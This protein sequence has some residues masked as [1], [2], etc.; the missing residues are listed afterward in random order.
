MV[1]FE[2]K[3]YGTCLC[4]QHLLILL[5]GDCLCGAAC[6]VA[7]QGWWLVRQ[8]HGDSL[9]PTVGTLLGVILGVRWGQ[10][11]QGSPPIP[12][13][14]VLQGERGWLVFSIGQ[15]GTQAWVAPCILTRETTQVSSRGF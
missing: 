7:I 12:S 2:G 15:V 3:F 9:G 5:G 4:L 8:Q 13:A 14:D 11:P 1:I 10:V 6:A